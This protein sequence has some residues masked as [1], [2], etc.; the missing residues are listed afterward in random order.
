MN[1]TEFPLLSL[2]SVTSGAQILAYRW[3]LYM[4]P[5]AL[6]FLVGTGTPLLGLPQAP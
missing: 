2:P 1:L 6:T 4:G 3:L 5:A